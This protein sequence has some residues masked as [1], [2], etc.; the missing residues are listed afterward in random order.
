MSSEFDE[1]AEKT[2]SPALPLSDD[3]TSKPTPDHTDLAL[4]ARGLVSAREHEDR[5]KE[6]RKN[7][8][9]RIASMAGITVDDVGEEAVLV[10]PDGVEIAVSRGERWT[11]DQDKLSAIGDVEVKHEA[12]TVSLSVPRKKFESM[13]MAERD[14]LMDALTRKPG[15]LSIK[16]SDKGE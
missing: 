14:E 1:W 8:E 2:I 15:L 5:A 4:L 16:V 6:A 10:T 7:I 9:E 3:P 13:S 12:I 11:W